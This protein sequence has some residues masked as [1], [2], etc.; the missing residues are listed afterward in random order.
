MK[1]KWIQFLSD[2]YLKIILVF[3]S[4]FLLIE[5]SAYPKTARAFPRLVLLFMLALVIMDTFTHV[6]RTIRTSNDTEK[7][8]NETDNHKADNNQ[9]QKI[10]TFFLSH[11]FRIFF[12]ILLM[13]VFLIFI[14]L[15]GFI[16]STFIFVIVAAWVLGFRD[17]Q[18]LLFSAILITGFMYLI[19]IT[20]MKSILPQGVLLEFFLR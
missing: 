9:S 8:Y 2:G 3:L 5:S 7:I 12:V 6:L 1:H 13:F 10:R 18:K 14:H 4:I 19:F 20:I 17:R 15:F 11:Y 16:L